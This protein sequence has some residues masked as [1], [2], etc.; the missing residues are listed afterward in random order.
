MNRE[1]VIKMHI[2]S[3]IYGSPVMQIQI[4]KVTI[5]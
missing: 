1:P 4:Q 2:L 5:F 3:N